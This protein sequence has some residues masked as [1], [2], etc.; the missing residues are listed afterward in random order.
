MV[1]DGGLAETERL[2]EVAD[3]CLVSRLGLDQAQQP[4]PGRIRDGF[5]RPRELLGCV[6]R[7]RLL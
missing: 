2:G 1:A 3:A 5:E 6:R 7:E 4:Q